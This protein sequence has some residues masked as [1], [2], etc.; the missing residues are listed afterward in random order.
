[1]SEPSYLLVTWAEFA[2]K[3]KHF[4]KLIE[5]GQYIAITKSSHIIATIHPYRGE[6]ISVYQP[7]VSA[8]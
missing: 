5:E 4:S 2:R 1:M 3:G 7:D 8:E 6:D